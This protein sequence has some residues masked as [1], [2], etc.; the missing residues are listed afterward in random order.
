[1]IAA[2]AAELRERY[3]RL[4]KVSKVTIRVSQIIETRDHLEKLAGP[5]AE[6]SATMAL[7][8][9]RIRPED[10]AGIEQRIVQLH[11]MISESQRSFEAERRQVVALTNAH[12]SATA[13]LADLERAWAAYR[14]A[15]ILRYRELYVLVARIPYLAAQAES[16]NGA[17][18]SASKKAA[19]APK[20]AA[21]I[22]A[23]DEALAA[24]DAAARAFDT[25]PESVRDF[26]RRVI[27]NSAT[28]ANLNRDVIDWLREHDS[29]GL[30][31]VQFG[32]GDS[33]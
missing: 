11:W 31:S 5:V 16:L 23:F 13:I 29:L 6:L 4:D 22:R 26:L 19:A 25:L 32:T 30:F 3:A 28:L 10:R 8:A 14:D 27:S 17:L 24:V 21:A 2:Q 20:S 33:R 7:I 15:A 1:M 12:R 18:A 9:N